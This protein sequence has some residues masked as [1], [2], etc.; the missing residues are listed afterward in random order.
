MTQV[1][2]AQIFKGLH[3]KGDPV[4]LYNIWDAG[5]AQALAKEGAKAIATGSWSVAAAQ[6]YPDGEML[7]MDLL[8]CIAERIVASTE[9]PV[10][11]DFEG[12]YAVDPEPLAENIRQ[13]IETGAVGLNFEDRI[14]Q[15]EGLYPLEQQAKRIAAIRAQADAQAV[16]F[17]INARTDLFLRE[18][19]ED[20]AAQIE[21]ALERASAY[22]EAGADG[23]FV[24]GLTEPDLIAQIVEG[25]DLPANVMMRGIPT[26]QSVAE[27][28]VARASYGPI[29][30][31]D[32]LGDLTTRYRTIT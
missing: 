22:K 5:G 15:G 12:G 13:L 18:N 11:I 19:P 25:T 10:T 30:Y 17:F 2:K 16:P 32:A 6:G 24:P 9:L 20:H 1:E 7:P 26:V 31:F 23:F 29:P 28:G 21:E 27:L 8:L 14:V 3:K 4:V